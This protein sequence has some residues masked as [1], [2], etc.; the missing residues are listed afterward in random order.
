MSDELWIIL[1]LVMA[2][3]L[4]SIIG[5]QRSQAQ[6]S[7]GLRDMG[8]LC[9]GSALFT[10]VSIYGFGG[11]E[12]AR[13]AA[14]I[15]TGVGFLGAGAIFRTNQDVVKG[16]TT[17]TTIWVTAGIG[18]A[19][20]AGMYYVAVVAAVLVLLLLVLRQWMGHDRKNMDKPE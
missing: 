16:I 17:A 20:G 18:M 12:P 7:A 19:C 2:V 4:G 15:V 3:I 8:L 6:K 10:V 9:L 11:E 5:I 14:G 1:R 13:I